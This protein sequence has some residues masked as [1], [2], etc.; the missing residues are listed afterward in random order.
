MSK[1]P[2]LFLPPKPAPTK[3]QLIAAAEYAKNPQK[4]IELARKLA[5][6]REEPAKEKG[7]A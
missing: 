2:L 4:I 3:R 6:V 5:F 7:G 1:K